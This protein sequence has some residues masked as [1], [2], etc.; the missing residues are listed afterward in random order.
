MAADASSTTLTAAIAAGSAI[1][2]GIIVAAASLRTSTRTI[3]IENITKERAKWRDKVRKRSLAVHRNAV[4]GDVLA[5]EEHH[6]E[7]SLILNPLDPMDRAI[8]ALIRQLKTTPDESHLTEFADRIS[9]LLKHDWQRAKWE[10]EDDWLLLDSDA[11]PKPERTTYE[12]FKRDLAAKKP[13]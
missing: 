6:L 13:R 8:L 3:K 9:L 7:F 4:K 11:E 12:Q 10:A 2:G 5:L 1:I